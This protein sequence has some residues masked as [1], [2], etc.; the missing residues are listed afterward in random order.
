MADLRPLKKSE[1]LEVRIPYATKEAFMAR[2]RAEGRSAS[3]DVRRFIETRLGP[4]P[5]TRRTLP[6]LA[7]GLIAAALAAAAAPSLAQAGI[8]GRL[9]FERLD[10]NGDGVITREEFQR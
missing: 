9:T 8:V 4:P 6:Y 5:P 1:T 10:R 3:E 7:A 2:C